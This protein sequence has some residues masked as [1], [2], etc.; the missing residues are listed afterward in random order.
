MNVNAKREPTR[1]QFSCQRCDPRAF[2]LG[3][4][5]VAACRPAALLCYVCVCV[6]V[7]TDIGAVLWRARAGAARVTGTRVR[8]TATRR[9][10][11]NMAAEGGRER[12]G[13][14]EV[15]RD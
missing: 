10:R 13:G 14:R 7:C 11:A 15:G 4:G 9:E 1:S 2:C 6:C 8:A 5:A 12:E 3:E